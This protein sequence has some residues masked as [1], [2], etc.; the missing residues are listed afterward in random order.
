MQNNLALATV[1]GIIA[2]C[3][4]AC[5]SQPASAPA[6][7]APATPAA[8]SARGDCQID[9]IKI[10]Q[11]TQGS[12]KAQEQKVMPA[13]PM[14]TYGASPVAP[15]ETI[16]FD[17]PNGPSLQVMCYYNPQHTAVTRADLATQ[18]AQTSDTVTYLRKQGFCK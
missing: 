6:A 12:S 17:I 11:A 2:V 1:L 4:S 18:V 9:P 10:C 3:L 5:A 7:A 15:P 13:M 8:S 16:Q 14:G